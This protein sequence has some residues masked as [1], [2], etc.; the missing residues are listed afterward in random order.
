MVDLSSMGYMFT[1]LYTTLCKFLFN[2]K[3]ELF[4]HFL[5]LFN[6]FHLPQNIQFQC[7]VFNLVDR[8][9][10]AWKDIICLLK[11]LLFE[12]TLANQ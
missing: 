11:V 8:W 2:K 5:H 3:A 10:N 6:I 4:N 7:H 1:V 12:Q 9:L